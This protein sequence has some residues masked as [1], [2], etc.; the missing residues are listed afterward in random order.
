LAGHIRVLAAV[1]FT[2]NRKPIRAHDRASKRVYVNVLF[3]PFPKISPIWGYLKTEPDMGFFS[4]WRRAIGAHIEP[5]LG[6]VCKEAHR[7]NGC[8]RVSLGG[9]TGCW[10]FSTIFF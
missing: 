10:L 6:W 1:I 2:I 7:K 3:R 4:G 5:G 8:I 9:V